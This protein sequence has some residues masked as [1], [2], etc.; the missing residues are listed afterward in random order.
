[1]NI[2]FYEI[3][4]YNDLSQTEVGN[5]LG[6]VNQT[7]SRWENSVEIIPLKH[8]N[9]L[10]NYYNVS[11]DYLVGLNDLNTISNKIN[12]LNKKEIGKNLLKFR[13]DNNITQK[14]LADLL[15]T[16]HST[17]SAYEN[18]KTTILTAFAIQI[19]KKYNISLDWLCNRL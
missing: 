13:K 17:I 9:T 4:E 7:Y 16:T 6:V 2:K 10:S 5:I 12:S 11:M 3:R 14:E 1:M 19:C 8:V 18:G 15:C